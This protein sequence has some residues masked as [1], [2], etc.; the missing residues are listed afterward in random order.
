MSDKFN[1]KEE[2]V[3]F[4]KIDYRLYFNGKK[5][6]DKAIDELFFGKLDVLEKRLEDKHKNEG[7][8]INIQ[9]INTYSMVYRINKTIEFYSNIEL[10]DYFLDQGYTFLTNYSKSSTS[11]TL[12]IL[13]KDLDNY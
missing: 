7:D 3:F 6:V 12:F 13:R 8:L 9:L 1:F 5:S 11:P 2:L 4:K 10:L